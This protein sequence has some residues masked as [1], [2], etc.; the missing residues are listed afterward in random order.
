MSG[1]F[2]IEE[3]LFSVSAPLIQP[4]QLEGENGEWNDV[5]DFVNNNWKERQK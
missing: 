2:I 3:N 4:S 1:L 5:C